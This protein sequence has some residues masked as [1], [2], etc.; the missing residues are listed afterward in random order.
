MAILILFSSFFTEPEYITLAPVFLGPTA[1]AIGAGLMILYRQRLHIGWVPLLI[2]ASLW[3]I[4]ASL[5]AFTGFAAFDVNEPSE[6]WSNLGF[7]LGL[8]L[9]PG[10]LLAGMGIVLYWSDAAR[11]RSQKAPDEATIVTDLK[12]NEQH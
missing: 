4:G 10:I 11:N 9:V 1:G 7:S 12:Q 8:C 3:F 6:F 2:A 5:L